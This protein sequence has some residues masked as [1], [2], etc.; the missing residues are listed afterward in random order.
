M[1][2]PQRWSHPDSGSL[3]RQNHHLWVLLCFQ[4]CQASQTAGEK[5]RAVCLFDV[6]CRPNCRSRMLSR[7]TNVKCS[8]SAALSTTPRS[9]RK[10]WIHSAHK[11]V[12]N[13]ADQ[14]RGR[15]HCFRRRHFPTTKR[16]HLNLNTF[17]PFSLTI[18][19]RTGPRTSD[20]L[21]RPPD[22]I[23]RLENLTLRAS[24]PNVKPQGVW[25][26]YHSIP[27]VLP[28]LGLRERGPTQLQSVRF[29]GTANPKQLS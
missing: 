17:T 1:V 25:T 29:G 13:L 11:P 10:G 14:V 22:L 23:W 15:A 18:P 28:I 19:R 9:E 27:A 16:A 6:S 26:S 8:T 2:W 7:V 24:D 12:T 3:L 20:H 4:G 5:F 21:P